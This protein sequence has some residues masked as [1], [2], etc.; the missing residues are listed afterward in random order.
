MNC[1]ICGKGT[2][3]LHDGDY[4]AY[5]TY[6]WHFADGRTMQVPIFGCT[7]FSCGCRFIQNPETGAIV[8]I[9]RQYKRRRYN[10]GDRRSPL[11]Y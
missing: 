9:P 3:S 8:A 10:K 5:G 6:T 1:P 7:N 4:D 2:L 11:L